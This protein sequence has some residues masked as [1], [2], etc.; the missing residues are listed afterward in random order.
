MLGRDRAGFKRLVT[1]AKLVMAGMGLPC[2]ELVVPFLAVV[3]EA[4]DQSPAP[5]LVDPDLRQQR[6][7]C[8]DSRCLVRNAGDN[9]NR[10][11][12]TFFRPLLLGLGLQ[13]KR[14]GVAVMRE[15]VPTVDVIFAGQNLGVMLETLA[16]VFVVI[17]DTDFGHVTLHKHHRHCVTDA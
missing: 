9:I 5:F 17:N 12:P 13:P 2:A 14:T 6:A 1:V 4:G 11:D 10:H 8:F 3:I 7:A 15:L 16:A